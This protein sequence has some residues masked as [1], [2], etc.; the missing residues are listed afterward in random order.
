[1]T[2]KPRSRPTN[3]LPTAP[4]LTLITQ[5]AS[6][7]LTTC[8]RLLPLANSHFLLLSIKASLSL[9]LTRTSPC[10]VRIFNFFLSPDGCPRSPLFFSQHHPNHHQQAISPVARLISSTSFSNFPLLN[11]V[12]LVFYLFFIFYFPHTSFTSKPRHRSREVT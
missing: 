4:S 8:R 1:M 9:K 2:T 10:S 7:T 5:R 6:S 11:I 12:Y 3:P